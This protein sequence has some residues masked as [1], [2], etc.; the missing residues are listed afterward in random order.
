ML[1]LAHDYHLATRRPSTEERVLQFE[2]FVTEYEG[3]TVLD[4]GPDYV[5][6]GREFT[7]ERTSKN[8]KP[9]TPKYYT[10][11]ENKTIIWFEDWFPPISIGE[12]IQ[13]INSISWGDNDAKSIG[14]VINEEFEHE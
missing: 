11:I 13:H 2:S 14:T 7:I 8:R 4:I 6:V 12:K 3:Y 1:D 9:N 10:M 5:I